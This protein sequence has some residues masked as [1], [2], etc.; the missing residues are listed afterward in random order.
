MRRQSNADVG[1][2]FELCWVISL[3]LSTLIPFLEM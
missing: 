3:S 1:T 2:E